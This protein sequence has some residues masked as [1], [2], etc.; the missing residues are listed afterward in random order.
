MHGAIGRRAELSEL[1][2]A[3]EDALS[4]QR[5]VAVVTGEP[6]IGKTHL[7]EA[8]ISSVERQ[9]AT[10]CWGRCWEG[11][12]AP[13]YWPW[14]QVLRSVVM[15]APAKERDQRSVGA[16]EI[17][18]LAPQ[19]LGAPPT[20]ELRPTSRV[21]DA[22]VRLFDAV[23]TF[24]DESASEKP[25]I[26][27][28]EDLHAADED[29][30]RLLQHVVRGQTRSRLLIAVSCRQFGDPKSRQERLLSSMAAHGRHLPLRG[31]DEDSV[32]DLLVR[33][34]GPAGQELAREVHRSTDGHPLLV[35]QIALLAARSPSDS[36]DSRRA[37][38]PI[39][40][41]VE[42][43]IRS[44]LDLL[45]PGVRPVLAK[46]AVLGRVFELGVLQALTG[47][48]LVTLLDLLGVARQHGLVEEQSI[49]Q[50]R[51]AH[52]LVAETLYQDIAESERILLHQRAGEILERRHGE[53][54][55]VEPSTLAHHFHRA[56][57]MENTRAIHY[58]CL[59]AEAAL[60]VCAF[61]EAAAWYG[62][63]FT[64]LTHGPAVG[65]ERRCELLLAWGGAL[66]RSGALAD[67]RDLH[68]RAI[69]SARRTGAADLLARA[70]IGLAG[71]PE[72]K[73]DPGLVRAL[74]DSL[75][76]LPEEDSA[77]R[78]QLLVALAGAT[79]DWSARPAL[80]RQGLEMAR[81]VGDPDTL[82][83]ALWGWHMHNLEPE[84]LSERLAS[85]EE[86]E[87]LA[88]EAGDRDRVVMAMQWQVMDLFEQGDISRAQAKLE[89]AA[90][91][92]EH[93]NVPV[94]I[95]GTTVQRTALSLL[96]AGVAEAELGAQ[97]ALAMGERVGYLDV[98]NVYLT[99]LIAV[100][101]EQGRFEEM[102]ALAHRAGQ[103]FTDWRRNYWPLLQLLAVAA[104]GR[105]EEAR[106]L[107]RER[108]ASDY[109]NWGWM[110]S[111]GPAMLAQACWELEDSDSAR[112]VYERLKAFRE[113][114]VVSGIMNFSLGSS[115]RYLGQLT[116]LLGDDAA[117]DAHFEA[118]H[119]M[120]RR[121]GAPG[122]LA[123]GQLDHARMLLRRGHSDDD[124]GARSLGLAAYHGFRELGM[125][126][127][128]QQA[129][130]VLGRLDSSA[131]ARGATYRL[132]GDEWV[133]AYGDAVARL[134][135]TIGLR[136]LAELLR[137]PGQ[138]IGVVELAQADP[139]D[140]E[141]A[142]H[143]VTRA[144]KTSVGRISQA[145]P[146]LGEHL[147]TTLHIGLRCCYRPDPRAPIDWAS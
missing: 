109:W 113:W 112:P 3:L 131:L 59:A 71:L 144:L 111:V 49:H 20:A 29:S 61:S 135:D 48:D 17:A 115:E 14:I 32:S 72:S 100:R 93:L 103:A 68:R 124:D 34:M 94:L 84:A 2:A 134:R 58:G 106:T 118:A 64:A 55:G 47:D 104:Q 146:E 46:A 56:L 53:G 95:W 70:A 83:A 136:Y 80:S 6:G 99:Q 76:A 28:L 21:D 89:Q 81:R 142:R 126:H 129:M 25:L 145:L 130:V 65:E 38:L 86:L 119:H 13:A 7:L 8:F 16:A 141:R 90:R 5:A 102:E 62:R 125:A 1:R 91:E 101:R 40:S 44:R 87:R 9:E 85:A 30:L 96:R 23:T 139:A 138:E 97:E 15:Q 35:Q 140:S 107:L 117:A 33:E 43:V 110:A 127:Y 108:L 137:H 26:L 69:R 133:V 67:A 4:G 54:P 39:P 143:S 24:L 37:A 18:R 31:L 51:F 57:P 121:L 132:E 147:G 114:H 27:V 98:E 19:F 12:G 120:H 79:D 73:V 42:T 74:W 78:A 77:W 22:Q 88:G 116:A 63:T 11:G 66:F 36:R 75:A 41:E 10:A 50:W 123:H 52:G 92:A 60:A 105:A 82:R 122:W 45:E 128:E